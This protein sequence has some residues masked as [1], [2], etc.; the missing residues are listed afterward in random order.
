VKAD[1]AFYCGLRDEST[2]QLRQAAF[3]LKEYQQFAGFHL[4]APEFRLQFLA[5]QTKKAPPFQDGAFLLKL[6][7]LQ[8]VTRAT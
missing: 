7:C 6:R 8:A 1:G 3:Y 5:A 2:I 4:N